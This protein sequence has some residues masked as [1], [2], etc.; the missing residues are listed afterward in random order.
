MHPLIKAQQDKIVKMQNA[1]YAAQLAQTQ[2]LVQ[3]S[4]SNQTASPQTAPQATRDA[5]P[6]APMPMQM[7]TA[8]P[9]PQKQ[10]KTPWA[11]IALGIGAV[12]LISR[13]RR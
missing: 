11:L 2:Q 10:Q 7:P 13:M 8:V 9:T 4:Q 1:A 12:V 6:P 3:Q 5:Q